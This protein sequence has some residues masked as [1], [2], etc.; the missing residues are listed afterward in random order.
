MCSDSKEGILFSMM[1]QC[2]FYLYNDKQDA[3]YSI[4]KKQKCGAYYEN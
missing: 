1:L 4:N 2:D 3:V